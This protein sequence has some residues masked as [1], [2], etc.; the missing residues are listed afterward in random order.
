[1]SR[2]RITPT[3]AV[4]VQDTLRKWWGTEQGRGYVQAWLELAHRRGHP[5]FIWA[6]AGHGSLEPNEI[7]HANA[8]AE[9]EKITLAGARTYLISEDMATLAEHASTTMPIQ[10]IHESDLPTPSGIAFYESGVKAMD[11]QGGVMVI[12][13]FAWRRFVEDGRSCV[14]WSYYS[15]P[16]DDRL[17]EEMRGRRAKVPLM[18]TGE[19]LEVFGTE[20]LKPD[21]ITAWAPGATP[22]AAASTVRY[23][24]TMPVALWAMMRDYAECTTTPIERAARRRLEKAERPSPVRPEVIVVKLRRQRHETENPQP[25]SVEW[26]RRWIVNGH[27]RRQWYATLG[28]HRAKWIA[29]FVKGPAGKPLVVSRK[30]HHLVR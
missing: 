2:L 16:L 9:W 27:W 22:E 14:F 29:P 10:P 24:R 26:S 1:V 17:P 8:R 19:D 18:L 20:P 4:E 5:R 11:L 6:T 3:L 23:M 7:D 12:S 15:D 30:V 28:M 21:V 25:G 13:A